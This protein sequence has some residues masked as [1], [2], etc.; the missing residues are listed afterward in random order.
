MVNFEWYRTFKSIYEK[1]SL[2]AAAE[3]LFISQPGVSLHLSSLEGHVGHPLFSRGGRKLKPTEHGVQLYQAIVEPLGLL[4]AVERKYQK[5][6]QQDTPSLTLG[7][8][9]ETFQLML[10]RNLHRLSFNVILEFG[11]YP[12]LLQKLDQGVVDVVVS[13]QPSESKEVIQEI[14]GEEKLV[15]IGSKGVD[16]EA[17]FQQFEHLPR[18]DFADY[19]KTFKWY[20]PT[21][22]NEHFK[23]FWKTNF[24]KSP[25]F[26]A[27]YIV[28]NFN[29]IIRCLK[30]GDGLAVAPDFLCQQAFQNQD[31]KLLWAGDEPIVNRLRFIHRKKTNYQKQID[32]IK[33][34]IQ[35][36]WQLNGQS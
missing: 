31:L 23:R 14:F 2:T 22:T 16:T 30:E 33:K 7:M 8:C 4:E 24:R 12:A 17:F 28:P 10:E 32:Q 36:E 1:G 25:D 5:S 27:N 35:Q 19:L 34:V 26:R 11:A 13:P 6:N 29:S 15:L 9:F 20:A 3:H 21:G 18:E